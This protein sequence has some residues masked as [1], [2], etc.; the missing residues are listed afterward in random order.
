MSVLA[1]LININQSNFFVETPI[2]Y[3][4][5]DLVFLLFDTCCKP[6]KGTKL[7]SESNN[8]ESDNKLRLSSTG[9]T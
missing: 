6:V 3:I 2:Y 4:Q 5:K 1:A 9:S 7:F 8:Y